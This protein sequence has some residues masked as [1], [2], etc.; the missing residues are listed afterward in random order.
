GGVFVAL[1]A[2]RLFTDFSE[3]PIGLGAACLLGFAGWA[4]EGALRQ[5]TSRNFA[6]RLPLMA[7]LIGGFT[8]VVSATTAANQ[9]ALAKARNFYGVLRVSENID[10][11]GMKREMR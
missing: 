3:Y 8:A 6:V 7:L 11:N 4:R 1:L 5:W 9:P 2:P 10:L